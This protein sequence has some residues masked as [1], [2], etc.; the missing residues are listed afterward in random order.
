MFKSEFLAHWQLRSNDHV[1]D[2][3]LG[4]PLAWT[5][6]KDVSCHVEAAACHLS[7]SVAPSRG[8]TCG[9]A[10]SVRAACGFLAL[11]FVVALPRC[12]PSPGGSAQR[13][14]EPGVQ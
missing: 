9:P 1:G 11:S 13:Q 2:A 8:A 4:K 3:A 10:R 6:H 12:P 5:Q 7:R 14:R